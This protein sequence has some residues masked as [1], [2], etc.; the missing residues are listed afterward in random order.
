MRLWAYDES[1]ELHDRLTTV[2]RADLER[3]VPRGGELL[4]EA[5]IEFWGDVASRFARGEWEDAVTA[6]ERRFEPRGTK[7]GDHEAVAGARQQVAA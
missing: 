5:P 1:D 3:Y 2:K 7:K 4:P 6:I